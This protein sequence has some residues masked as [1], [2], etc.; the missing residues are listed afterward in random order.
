MQLLKQHPYLTS[1]F[2]S[3]SLMQIPPF[4]LGATADCCNADYKPR[5]AQKKIFFSKQVKDELW[6]QGVNDSGNLMECQQH[7]HGLLS[8]E[9][10]FHFL[11]TIKNSPMPEDACARLRMQ[12]HA[13]YTVRTGAE[14]R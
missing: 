13:S 2:K 8:V 5:D 11:G 10:H 4:K 3:Q 12:Y 14:K 1:N 7:L 6:L 9:E